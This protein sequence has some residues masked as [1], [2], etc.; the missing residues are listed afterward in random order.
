MKGLALHSFDPASCSAESLVSFW[1]YRQ[2]S[3]W[4]PPP[5]MIRAV[6]AHCHKRT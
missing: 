3:R 4:N 6:R 1:T 5:L 2:L